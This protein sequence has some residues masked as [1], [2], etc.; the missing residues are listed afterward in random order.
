MRVLMLGWEFPPYLTGGLGTACEGLTRALRAAGAEIIFVLPRPIPR[1]A[2]SHVQLR[3][4][5]AVLHEPIRGGWNGLP[6]KRSSTAASAHDKVEQPDADF[7]PDARALLDAQTEHA[8]PVAG[9]FE[10]REVAMRF[11]SPY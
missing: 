1:D 8:S 4:P 3:A 9:R 7:A 2:R 10:L 6:R 5:E 11:V